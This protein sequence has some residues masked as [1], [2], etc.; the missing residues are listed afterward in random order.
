V[1][2]GSLKGRRLLAPPGLRVRPTSD[3]AREALFDILG[4]RIRGSRFLDLF[5]G[6][7]AVGI[8]ARS[9]GAEVVV[10]VESDRTALGIIDR[11][12]EALGIAGGMSIVREPWPRALRLASDTG[13]PFSIV[14]ADPPY[15]QANYEE[16]LASLAGGAAPGQGQV[17]LDRDPLII[18]E[19]ED[20]ASI[21]T[22]TNDFRLQRRVVYGRAGFGFFRFRA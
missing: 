14:F 15:A 10:L 21:P 9:R 13:G 6:T 17:L 12:L 5:S 11:N 8:E 16:I 2:A 3:R 20:R 19:H 1:I 7:G 22:E 4:P 18:L